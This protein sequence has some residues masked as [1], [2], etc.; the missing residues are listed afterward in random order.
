MKKILLAFVVALML[1]L[2]SA[3][4]QADTVFVANMTNAQEPQTPVPVIPTTST[5]A[6]RPVSFGT[7]TFV[8]NDAQ[9]A[10][11]MT[12]TV[13]NIDINT[14]QTPNDTNDNLTAAHIH[15]SSDPS[16][17]PPATA[18]VVWG[19]FGTPDNDNNPDNLVVTPFANGVGGTFSSVW[20]LTEG[21]NTTLTAQLPNIFAGRSYINFHTVQFGGGEIRGQLQPVPEPATMI[22]LGTGLV[23]VAGRKLRRRRSE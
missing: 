14:L 4:I 21:Q 10:L 6:P 16:F 15:A 12:A 9:T 23:A 18:G 13:F 8:L 11:T 17:T 1:G 19:F 20:N 22:L 2:M 5:G 3:S 7:A